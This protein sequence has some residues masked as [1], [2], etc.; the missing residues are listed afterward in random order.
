MIAA[1]K[2]STVPE[3]AAKTPAAPTDGFVGKVQHHPVGP[4]YCNSEVV[5]IAHWAPPT[6]VTSKQIEEELSR[7]Q[8]PVRLNIERLTGVRERRVI[9]PGMTVTDM[10]VKVCEKLFAQTNIRPEMIDLVIFTSVSREYFEPATAVFLADRLGIRGAKAFDLSNAC[11][12]FVDG[13]MTADAMIQAGRSR[14]CL[15]VASEV[16]SVYWKLALKSLADGH[17]NPA[18]LIPNFTIGDG[19]AAMII[20]TRTKRP[21]SLVAKGGVRESY[22]EF[23]DLCL[24]RNHTEPMVTKS[25]ELFGAALKH[26]PKLTADLL[27]YMR[28]KPLQVDLVIPHQASK[29]VVTEA[30]QLVHI[31]ESKVHYTLDR[32]GNLASAAVPFTLSEAIEQGR[33]EDKKNI[34]IM[35]YGSGLGVGMLALQRVK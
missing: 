20:G 24:I 2:L 29:R 18:E 30:S 8:R 21:G 4:F 34:V 33:L 19:A 15:I 35:G 10:A 28:W 1:K 14:L 3:E 16:A 22:G 17:P 26:S 13:W 12:G 32:F 23:S 5:S 11:L 7:L 27:K 9:D 6:I 25:K 31:P